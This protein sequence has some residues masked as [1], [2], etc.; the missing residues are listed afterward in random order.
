MDKHEKYM[1]AMEAD[2]LA[3][4]VTRFRTLYPNGEAKLCQNPSQG[5]EF[6]NS[7]EMVAVSSNAR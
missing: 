3:R 1:I 6:L 5:F 7:A 2:A 4:D